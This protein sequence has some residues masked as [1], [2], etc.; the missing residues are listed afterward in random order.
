MNKSTVYCHG[1]GQVTA[2]LWE[3]H[4]LLVILGKLD[5]TIVT[6]LCMIKRRCNQRTT[7]SLLG[8]VDISSTRYVLCIC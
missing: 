2:G 3:E 7:W 1:I 4:C 8:I 5:L 6:V